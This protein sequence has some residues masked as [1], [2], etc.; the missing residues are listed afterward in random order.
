MNLCQMRCALGGKL[1]WAT[2]AGAA[3]LLL[4]FCCCC[5]LAAAGWLL[6]LLAV[7]CCRLAAGWL[8]L[9]LAD[10]CR[11]CYLPLGCCWCCCLLL[12][13][14]CRCRCCGLGYKAYSFA[15]CHCLARPMTIGGFFHCRLGIGNVTSSL[16]AGLFGETRC[17]MRKQVSQGRCRDLVAAWCPSF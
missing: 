6:L 10:W 15:A 1:D 16:V 3:G 14:A 11:C 9:L 12:A 8:L 5:C 7:G 17:S 4:V 2:F 13:A